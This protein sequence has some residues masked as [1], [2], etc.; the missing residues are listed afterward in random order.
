MDWG[1]APEGSQHANFKRQWGAVRAPVFR[2]VYR[3]NPDVSPAPEAGLELATEEHGEP[4][5]TTADAPTGSRGVADR[6]WE[7]VPSAAVGVAA[8]VGHRLL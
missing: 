3:P 1:T 4:R 2:Y 8:T 6:L 7:R 5:P